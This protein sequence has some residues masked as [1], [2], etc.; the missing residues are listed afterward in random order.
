VDVAGAREPVRLHFYL[1]GDLAA[2]QCGTGLVYDL[3]VGRVAPGRHTLAVWAA[4]GLGRRADTSMH[5]DLPL[6]DPTLATPAAASAPAAR[7]GATWSVRG[8]AT[9]IWR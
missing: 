1:D 7:R 8:L 6:V 2:V 4:D 9:R 3:A 5:V